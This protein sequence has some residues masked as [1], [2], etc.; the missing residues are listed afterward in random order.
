MSQS[1]HRRATRWII[2]A[3][4]LAITVALLLPATLGAVGVDPENI[5]EVARYVLTPIDLGGEIF[6]RLLKMVVVPLVVSSVMSGILGMGDV[7]KLGLPGLATVTYY[8]S[9]TF[10]AVLVGLIVVNAISPGA[11]MTAD[12]R[13]AIQQEFGGAE[14]GNNAEAEPVAE[15]DGR[16]DS[17]TD[18]LENLVLMLFTDNLFESAVRGD[19]LPLIGFSI[20]FAGL[21]TILGSRVQTIID[22]ILQTNEALMALILFIMRFAP[23][24]IFCLVAAR[25]GKANADGLF[26]AELAKTGW[27]SVSVLI[28]LSVHAFVTIPL[29][30]WVFT[31]RNP[32]RFIMQ[33]SE[34]LLTAFSTASS[35]ATLPVTMEKAID[36]AGVSR[37]SVDFV[38]PLGATI[39]MD[40]TALYEAVAAIFIAQVLG[41]DLSLAG[42]VTVALTATLA[43]IGAAGIP[44]AGLVTMV[45]VL[46]AVGLPAKAMALIISVDWLLDRF[47]TT[48]N[49]LGDAAGAAVVEKTF[50]QERLL[51]DE[52]A[53]PTEASV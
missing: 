31:R 19:L 8:V 2:L 40:G 52:T 48:V 46:N 9:T 4:L 39:N 38:L 49:V 50:N 1:A 41:S 51:A 16:A 45:I 29:I 12:E 26:L 33:I 6:L 44:E 35:S 23:L 25:F 3:I 22:V 18:I 10:L 20:F 43:A 5:G 53:S 30:L 13:A 14:N 32:Y 7:R 28:G 34:A 27:Y 17:I 37:R 36:E 11:R 47:R 42:Q 21:L 15:E 24:G